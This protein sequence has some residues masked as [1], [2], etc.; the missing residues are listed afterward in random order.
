M[1]Y[2][3]SLK[4][5][6]ANKSSNKANGEWLMTEYSLYDGYLDAGKI[7][8]KGYVICKI[9]KKEK[10]GDK[11]KGT[12]AN[13][14]FMRDVEEFIREDEVEDH[15]L[16]L[17]DLEDVDGGRI[18]GTDHVVEDDQLLDHNLLGYTAEDIDLDALDFVY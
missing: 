6:P 12:A 11:K 5:I 14:E 3:K 18:E 7:K 10:P 15:I 1:G 13:D 2:V 17:L 9:K 16:G 4:Y 8:K